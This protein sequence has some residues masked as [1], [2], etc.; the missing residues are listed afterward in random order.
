MANSFNLSPHLPFVPQ[1]SNDHGAFLEAL[2]LTEA[3]TTLKSHLPKD[4]QTQEPLDLRNRSV[5]ATEHQ[6]V[7]YTKAQLETKKKLCHRGNHVT[8]ER[9]KRYFQTPSAETLSHLLDQ[10]QTTYVKFWELKEI[11]ESIPETVPK[12]LL[13]IADDLEQFENHIIDFLLSCIPSD[14]EQIQDL[15]LISVW[16]QW[17]KNSKGEVKS[18]NHVLISKRILSFFEKEKMA[19]IPLT[20]I[21][22]RVTCC[23]LKSQKME[24]Y[25]EDLLPTFIITSIT[26]SLKYILFFRDTETIKANIIEFIHDSELF[27][28]A[29]DT[30]QWLAK[31]LNIAELCGSAL[32]LVN[33]VKCSNLAIIPGSTDT[34]DLNPNSLLFYVFRFGEN[35]QLAYNSPDISL[36]ALEQLLRF[37]QI[38]EFKKKVLPLIQ[39]FASTEIYLPV[40]NII[41][42]FLINQDTFHL[43]DIPNK[44]SRLYLSAVLYYLKNEPEK[45]ES[46]LLKS[47]VPEARWLLSKVYEQNNRL[48]EAIHHSRLAIQQGISAANLQLAL[49]LIKNSKNDIGSIEEVITLLQRAIEHYDFI[50][51]KDVSFYIQGIIDELELSETKPLTLEATSDETKGS[52]KQRRRPGS[53]RKEKTTKIPGKKRVQGSLTRDLKDQKQS[54]GEDQCSI[55]A[56]PVYS[57]SIEKTPIQ[58]ESIKSIPRIRLSYISLCVTQ[59][60]HNSDFEQARAV[61]EQFCQETQLTIQ[62]AS[63]A[64]MDLWSLRVIAKG[65]EHLEA[66]NA[67]AKQEQKSGELNILAQSGKTLTDYG[68]DRKAGDTVLLSDDLPKTQ[69]A[70]RKLIIDKALGWLCC[71]HPLDQNLADYKAQ[72]ITQPC[73]I[74]RHHLAEFEHSLSLTFVTGSFLSLIGHIH[75]DMATDCDDQKEKNRLKQKSGEFYSTANEFN[76]WRIRLKNEPSLRHRIAKKTPLGDI[77][78]LRKKLATEQ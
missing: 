52:R 43:I 11:V 55:N 57:T 8:L 31:N 3:I 74:A 53:T 28:K 66:F 1:T 64:H 63:F 36:S 60:L 10:F 2:A 65:S 76:S 54:P 7:H 70:I 51:A 27:K 40:L 35:G 29:Q 61:L 17:T 32:N 46:E 68:L 42:N 72:W 13:N 16:L 73:A 71:L 21:N 47:R 41:C 9:E 23:D 69:Q 5:K 6:V 4:L 50:D 18:A 75:G 34:P 24:P 78:R 77:Q 45:A 38:P 20:K 30:Q 56:S 49:L 25:D 37:L 14:P 48:E 67:S 15:F 62:Q 58:G 33:K 26:N 44:D 59:L 19:N 39:K 12:S 22:H